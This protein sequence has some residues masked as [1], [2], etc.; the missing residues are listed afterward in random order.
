MGIQMKINR[1]V[2]EQYIGERVS[3]RYFIITCFNDD[4]VL[5]CVLTDWLA[6]TTPLFRHGNKSQRQNSSQDHKTFSFLAHFRFLYGCERV[7]ARSFALKTHF[8][9]HWNANIYTKHEKTNIYINVFEVNVRF[10]TLICV[11]LFFWI[12]FCALML[13]RCGH[14]IYTHAR[15]CSPKMA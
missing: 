8:R 6:I 10:M 14:S 2:C 9:F 4:C 15:T 7:C 3:D 1:K 12:W 13:F 11:R 5:V